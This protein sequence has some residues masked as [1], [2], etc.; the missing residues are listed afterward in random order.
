MRREGLCGVVRGRKKRTTI[1]ADAA[2]CPLDRVRRQFVA[3]GPN[4]LWITD[5]TYVVTWTGFVYVAFVI[6]V[7]ASCIVV[8]VR[9]IDI[10]RYLR[11]VRPW[12]RRALFLAF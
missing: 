10:D 12:G 1:P 4:E 6:D 5:F 8:T 2:Q 11:S 3:S 9:G 7:F